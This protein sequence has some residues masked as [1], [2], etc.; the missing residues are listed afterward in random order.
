MNYK[1]H[2]N[3]AL[4]FFTSFNNHIK[5]FIIGINNRYINLLIFII[6]ILL[7]IIIIFFNINNIMIINN[8]K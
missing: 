6:N 7:Y 8:L 5:K 3:K 1:I 2:L 4:L